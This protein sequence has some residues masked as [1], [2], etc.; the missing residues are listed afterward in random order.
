[1]TS[2]V[3]A[4]VL[5]RGWATVDEWGQLKHNGQVPAGCLPS[6]VE[7]RPVAFCAVRGALVA[8]RSGAAS[9]RCLPATR[10]EASS[11]TYRPGSESSGRG[12]HGD[13]R[14]AG[15]WRRRC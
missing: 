12:L 1:M 6:R 4:V 13:T 7:F 11:L 2:T 8:F 14:S 9:C 3:R 10:R 5:S 15:R